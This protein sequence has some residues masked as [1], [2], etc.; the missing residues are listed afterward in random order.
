MTQRTRVYRRGALC[1]AQLY[2]SPGATSRSITAALEAAG[3]P[4]T[5]SASPSRTSAAVFGLAFAIAAW[6][7]QNPLESK[8]VALC[9][10][11]GP[12]SCTS[13]AGDGPG[14]GR[15]RESR[16]NKHGERKGGRGARERR[17]ADAAQ[18]H[19]RHAAEPVERRAGYG[20]AAGRPSAGTHRSDSRAT[21]S[22]GGRGGSHPRSL[23]TARGR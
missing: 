20:C 21:R 8:G 13:Y 7:G 9:K 17:R 16:L 19:R 6:H 1:L 12:G 18:Q 11:K 23:L 5:R 2:P 22:E 10:G 4:T 15:G 14:K 3:L